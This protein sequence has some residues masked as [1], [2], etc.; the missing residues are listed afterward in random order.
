MPGCRMR[1]QSCMVT[2][3][4][5]RTCAGDRGRS[6]PPQKS[7]MK[8]WQS[9][10]LI[11]SASVGAVS[12]GG[13]QNTVSRSAWS[14]SSG[15]G[16]GD[17]WLAAATRRERHRHCRDCRA[18][19]AGRPAKPI[20][21]GRHVELR[22]GDPRELVAQAFIA[23]RCAAPADR[24]RQSGWSSCRRRSTRR[25]WRCRARRSTRDIVRACRPKHVG[26]DLRQHGAVALALRRRGD[27]HRSRRR[28]GRALTVAVACAPFFGPA[29]RRS[30]G[31]STVV[32]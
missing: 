31:V 2:Y 4:S 25:P 19:D 8:P 26:D 16:P 24:R 28:A 13:V 1:P 14:M 21:L 5:M 18:R 11:S 30:S 7:K 6:R 12:C 10:E 20:S 9:E 32:M 27:V 22:G 3:L 29:L 15:S 23:A 17:Q